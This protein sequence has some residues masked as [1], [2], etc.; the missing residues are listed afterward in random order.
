[1]WTLRKRAKYWTY[2]FVPGFSG[3]LRYYG[4]TVY[5]SP[6]SLVLRIVCEQGLYEPE[7]AAR[8][9]R[10]VR[11]GTTVMDVGANIGLM[12]IPVLRSCPTC[13]VASFEPSPSSLPFLRQTAANGE[14]RER[15][16]IV[17]KGLA[18]VE[19]ELDFA[20]GEPS[21]ALFDGFGGGERLSGGRVVRVPVSTLDLEWSRLGHPDV[22]VVKIDV[23]GAEALV[24]EGAAGLLR[25]CKPAV[26]LEWHEP[27]LQRYSVE[28]ARLVRFARDHGY[29]IYTVP[30]GV[31]VDDE[32]TLGVQ[33]FECQNFLL[34]PAVAQNA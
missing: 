1:M 8:V 6:D 21:E 34:L 22:S 2:R 23:E 15:W 26:I 7:I 16:T 29:R 11:P 4:T 24:L 18:D 9:T 19:G 28:P 13:R 30:S 27:Y 17:G 20:I 5:L 10:L 32:C 14:F 3:R 31:P 25:M 12:A 33:M